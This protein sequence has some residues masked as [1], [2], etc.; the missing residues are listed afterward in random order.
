M[1]NSVVIFLNKDS[2]DR[3]GG[4]RDIQDE[5]PIKVRGTNQGS[6]CEIMLQGI[7]RLL[8]IGIPEKRDIRA[9][10][11]KEPIRGGGKFRYE[12]TKE[13]SF[14]LEAL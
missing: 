3:V 13:I 1:L 5:I 14:A 11:S 2:S 6:G 12:P 9:K 7:K 10:E 4:S 8:S